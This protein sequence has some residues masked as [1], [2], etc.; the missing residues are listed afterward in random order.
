MTL[1]D[2]LAQ[3]K[4]ERG[5]PI[6]AVETEQPTSNGQRKRS[7]VLTDPFAEV[8]RSVHAALVESL[9]PKLYDSRMT[10]TE[11]EQQVRSALQSVIALEDRPMTMADRA[12]IA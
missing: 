12:K 10:Q 11:L 4:R 3:A 2:R 1:A 9:G 6:A 5:A 7:S 8:K